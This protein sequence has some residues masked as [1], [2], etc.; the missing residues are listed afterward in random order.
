MVHTDPRGGLLHG[1]NVY[2][3][4]EPIRVDDTVVLLDCS[5]HWGVSLSVA[6]SL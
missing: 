2:S 6:D 1:S 3:G 5:V 4:L